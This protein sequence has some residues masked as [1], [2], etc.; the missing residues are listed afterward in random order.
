MTNSSIMVQP[1]MI[2]DRVTEPEEPGYAGGGA[3]SAALSY[4]YWFLGTGDQ[5][6]EQ[7]IDHES[8]LTYSVVWRCVSLISQTIASLGWHIF[9]RQADERQKVQVEDDVAWLLAVQANPELSAYEFR[10]TMLKDAL[11]WG[12]GYAEIER[13]GYGRPVWL[14]RLAPSRVEPIRSGR[15]LLY[16]VDNGT[17]EQPSYLRPENVFHLKGLGPDGLVGYSV[18]DMAR[19]T[20]SLGQDQEAFGSSFFKR[21]PM[22]GGILEMPGN[23]K[24]SERDATQHTFQEA[25]GGSK[26]AGRVVVVSGGMKFTPLTLP[27]SDAQWIEGR[28]FS[29]EDICR[30]FGVPPH[31]AFDLT[32]STNNNIEHQ[33]IEWVQDC[34]LS[35]ARRLESEADIKLFGRVNRG[36]KYTR[37]NLAT[38]LRGD[39]QTQTDTVTKQVTSGLR[40]VNEGREFF[41]LNPVEGGDTP[42]IQGAMIP[43][44]QVIDPPGPPAPVV[45]PKEPEEDEPADPPE[46]RARPFIELLKAAFTRMHR[47]KLDKARRAQNKGKLQEHIAE[48]YGPPNVEHVADELRPIFEAF[49]AGKDVV[50]A[51]TAAAEECD[52]QERALL[53]AGVTEWPGQPEKA[54]AASLKT[55][56]EAVR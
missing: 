47:V 53:K 55:L 51:T 9:E 32:R 45:P 48:F 3:E 22:P 12:N 18:I 33:S 31:K 6:K 16:E 35:W 8:A 46:D 50:A 39:S 13:D 24:K 42:L 54:A 34:L 38:L 21:G 19:R 10:Q 15:Q 23:V 56:W 41:D 44:D 40:T 1:G 20:I 14:W 11:T 17:G 30:F 4:A 25:Y 36:R 37:I 29:A 27:N 7:R 49:A 43:L 52:S 2:L 26:K 28:R 5:W